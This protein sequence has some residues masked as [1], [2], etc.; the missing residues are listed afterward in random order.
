MSIVQYGKT[1]YRNLR[2]NQLLRT[3]SGM[4]VE[5]AAAIMQEFLPR[6]APSFSQKNEIDPQYDVMIII[7]VYNVGNYLEQC[8]DS[9]LNQQTS[10]TYQ[11]VFVDDGST[12]GSGAILD[13]RISAPHVVIHK[14]NGGVS[15]ARNDALRRITGRYVMFVDSDDYLELTTI[16]R[17]VRTADVTGANIVEGS[18]VF[19]D[20]QGDLCTNCHGDTVSELPYLELYG[21]PWGK[22]LAS[23]LMQD[24]CFPVGFLFEDTVMATLLHPSSRLNVSIPEVVY[25]Y[26]DNRT[27]ITHS[28]KR[29]KEAV[30][31]Y[32]MMKYCLEE[33][34]RRGDCLS[35]ENYVRYLQ[36]IRRNW[37]R[38]TSLTEEAQKAIFVLSCD[39]FDR[40]LPFHYEGGE[41]RM[42]LLEQVI[43]KR[44]YD[45]YCFL[46][47]R[48]DIL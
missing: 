7:P 43:R 32:W 38:T 42:S 5:K 8:I 9:I 23:K 22:V 12:D 34:I 35:H 2:F 30:D 47:E 21:F 17:L 20:G 44:S 6:N 18:H 11:A 26:R 31:S 36:A 40:C 19:F 16:E 24:F 10:Y 25:H 28:S 41:N 45:A 15:A 48:W 3:P 13:R 33:R 14:A 4:N 37:I 39:L 27:G 46:M 1:V 29:Q